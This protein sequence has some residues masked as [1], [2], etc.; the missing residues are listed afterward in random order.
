MRNRVPHSGDLPLLLSGKV[1][2]R[3][4]QAGQLNIFTYRKPSKHLE[5]VKSVFTV[6][7][8]LAF[9]E[10]GL[11]HLSCVLTWVRHLSFEFHFG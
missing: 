10:L 3:L 2:D 5:R 11:K 4:S 7:V 6:M 8:N 9:V 1:P